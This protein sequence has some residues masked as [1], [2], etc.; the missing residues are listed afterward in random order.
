MD[1]SYFLLGSLFIHTSNMHEV[2]SCR[3]ARE[4]TVANCTNGKL[5]NFS[6]TI[7]RDFLLKNETCVLNKYFRNYTSA[8]FRYRFLSR[9]IFFWG[10]FKEFLNILELVLK[11]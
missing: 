2:V 8:H 10:N 5:N 6:G 1:K 9:M 4:E 11:K 3:K 7:E